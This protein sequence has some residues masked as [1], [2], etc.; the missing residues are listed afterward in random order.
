MRHVLLASIVLP[1]L[2]AVG[3]SG[4]SKVGGSSGSASS[5]TTGNGGTT[6]SLTTG[7][8]NTGTSTGSV[9]TSSGSG[10]STGASGTSTTSAGSS[11]GS[12]GTNPL[13]TARPYT[14]A[15]PAGFDPSVKL[16][17]IVMLHGYGSYAAQED[18]YLGIGALVDSKHFFY[19]DPDGTLDGNGK[20]F[21]NATDACCNFYGS[22]VDDVAYLTAV[23][24]D[25]AARYPVDPK[26]VYVMGHS[27]GGFMTH[28]MACERAGRIA[29]VLSLAG[30]QN[31][32][33]ALC[34]PSEPVSVVELH[35]D[36]DQTILYGGGSVSAGV[37]PYPSAETTV[38]DWAAKDGCG[39][40]HAD[41]GNL[42]LVGGG[43]AG[44]E[45]NV[46][47]FSGCTRGDVELWTIQGGPHVPYPWTSTFAPTVIDWLFAHPK[48]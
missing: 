10:A 24:D 48:P 2:I 39:T 30:A 37:P 47:R 12:T 1:A 32:D 15:A 6:G 31:H 38:S 11:S 35:G 26:R 34:S 40:T 5:A 42:D 23:I 29:A 43:L 18:G 21:W 28:R 4:S 20:R 44:D 45:T 33:P 17:L 22:T 25:M 13:I 46:Q 14:S 16:P 7:G 36:A 41:A 3:C 8:S 19:A 9:T 27:N